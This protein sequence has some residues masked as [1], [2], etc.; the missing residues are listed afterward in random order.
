VA[1]P[2]AESSLSSCPASQRKLCL[3]HSLGQPQFGLSQLSPVG[4][5]VQEEAAKR[6][7]SQN[8]LQQ[9]K[10]RDQLCGGALQVEQDPLGNPFILCAM[11][12]EH[13]QRC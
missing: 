12:S 6:P 3:A 7:Q 4:R 2:L 13:L 5:E 10:S 9:S 11:P 8:A 1:T